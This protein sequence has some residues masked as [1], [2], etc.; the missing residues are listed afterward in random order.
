MDVDPGASIGS[1]RKAWAEVAARSRRTGRCC[2]GRRCTGALG[3]ICGR[4]HGRGP[5][6]RLRVRRWLPE[7]CIIAREKPVEHALGLMERSRL[8]EAQFGDEA[9]LEGTEGPF[10]PTLSL[11]AA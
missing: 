7:S 9:I 11:P 6:G 10:D 3:T 1:G 8:R 2:P 5:P 4:V